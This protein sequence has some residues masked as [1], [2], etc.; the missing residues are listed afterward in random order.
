MGHTKAG[1]WQRPGVVPATLPTPP[2]KAPRVSAARLKPLELAILCRS[3]ATLLDSGVSV[4]KA[5]AVAGDKAG[6]RVARETAAVSADVRAGHDLSD[7]L[8]RRG[9]A[10]PPLMRDLVRVA[11]AS[12][13]LPETLRALSEHFENTVRLRKAFVSQI[14]WP[15]FQLTAAV[16]IIALV[17]WVLGVVSGITGAEVDP[18]GFGLIGTSGALVWLGLTF[19][20]AAA[21][22]AAWKLAA[23]TLAGRRLF[24]PL[25]LAIPVVGTCRRNFALARFSWA[26]ALTQDSGMDV[27]RCLAASLPATG[28]GAFEAAYP[29]VWSRVAAGETLTD[30]LA[31]TGLFPRDYLHIFEVGEQTGSIPETLHRVGPQLEADARRSLSALVS[32]LGWVVWGLVAAFI[33]FLIFRLAAFYV[34][35]I[36]GVLDGM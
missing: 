28:N 27:K 29:A 2:P 1:A 8:K 33:T 12:G 31:A 30:A 9:R 35:M 6:T 22:F 10:F 20:T 34:G 26:F 36:N 7:S 14:A 15:V 24:D 4:F 25:L 5:L 11:E 19:G 3:L 21:A 17:I 32:A 13:T 18:L 16:L 23:R